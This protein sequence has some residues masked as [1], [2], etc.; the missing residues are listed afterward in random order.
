[1][2]YYSKGLEL[3]AGVSNT[4]LEVPAGYDA[5]VTMLFISNTGGSTHSVAATWNDG[6]SINFLSGKSV[7]AGDFIQFGGEPGLYLIMKEG[8]TLTVTPDAASSFSVIV[9]FELYPKAPRFNLWN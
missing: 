9:S 8:D 1:M 6:V 4:V 3:T 5:K 7:A 2:T